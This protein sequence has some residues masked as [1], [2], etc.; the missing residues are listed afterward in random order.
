MGV[1]WVQGQRGL[2]P[3]LVRRSW[4]NFSKPEYYLDGKL[5]TETKLSV[6]WRVADTPSN[7]RQIEYV[8]PNFKIVNSLVAKVKGMGWSV[9]P[10]GKC[11]QIVKIQN[12]RGQLSY[13]YL[14]SKK[15]FGCSCFW[16]VVQL[17]TAKQLIFGR[18]TINTSR[19]HRGR[20]RVGKNNN[21][22]ILCSL[23]IGF[24]HCYILRSLMHIILGMYFLESFKLKL[25]GIMSS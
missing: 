17:C 21:I 24:C 25:G 22:R 12:F 6:L 7:L 15:T 23:I 8:K 18:H 2:G 14:F 16:A 4:G 5:T 1:V 3:C 13:W 19:R 20:N 11:L 10:F 9:T